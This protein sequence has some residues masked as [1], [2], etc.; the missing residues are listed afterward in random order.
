MNGALSG[1]YEEFQQSLWKSTDEY[2]RLFALQL[3]LKQLL[4]HQFVTIEKVAR[5]L[6]ML[7]FLLRNLL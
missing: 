1:K 4:D 3:F 5:H 6:I 2:Y 7:G